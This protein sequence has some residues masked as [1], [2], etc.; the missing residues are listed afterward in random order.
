T[1]SSYLGLAK[2]FQVLANWKTKTLYFLLILL[3]V[4]GPTLYILR[5]TSAG[6]GIWLD[7]FFSWGLDP[8]DIGGAPLTQWWT[9]FDWAVWIAYAP[10][11]GLFLAMISYGRTI[12]EF[13]IINW[14][15]PAVFGIIWFGVWGGTALNL[16]ESNAVDLVAVIKE[17]GAIA[18]LWV[19]L[20]NLPFGLGVVIVPLLLVLSLFAY[21]VAANSMTT[22]IAG[23]CMKNVPIGEEAP[24][25]M[26]VIWGVLI[27]SISVIMAAFGGGLQGIDGIKQ[28]AAAG[29]FTVLFIFLLQLLSTIKMFFFDKI[30]E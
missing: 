1:F 19:F 29:G 17:H 26:K 23:M 10:L 21:A 2:G 6:M 4:T 16:Q 18:G 22:T 13:M 12:R 7:N 9:L 5:I 14:I 30:E 20:Q 15:L 24:P 3:F 8:I 25:S 28:L 27:G 11:M